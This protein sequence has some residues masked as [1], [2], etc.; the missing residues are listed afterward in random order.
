[1]I[2]SKFIFD[3]IIS[4]CKEINHPKSSILILGFSFKEDCNDYRNTK[5]LNLYNYFSKCC[6]NIEVFDPLVDI[7]SIRKD[8]NINITNEIPK[9]TYDIVIHAVSHKAFNSI[10]IDNLRKSKSIIYDVKGTLKGKIDGRL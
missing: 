10:N 8:Y 9:K 3:E 5:V 2:Q 1:M 6:L 7:E 4:L